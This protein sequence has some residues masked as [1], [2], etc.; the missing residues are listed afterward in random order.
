M[1]LPTVFDACSAIFNVVRQAL[2][3]SGVDSLTPKFSNP[4]DTLN[5]KFTLA[6]QAKTSYVR[7][8]S[9]AWEQAK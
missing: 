5:A 4:S 9:G 1:V 2:L 3:T 8:V 6:G 7:T